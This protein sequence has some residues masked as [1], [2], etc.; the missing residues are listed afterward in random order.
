MR[1]WCL[2]LLVMFAACGSSAPPPTLA[3]G[4]ATSAEAAAPEAA[5]QDCEQ[6]ALPPPDLFLDPQRLAERRRFV[7]EAIAAVQASPSRAWGLLQ[8]AV[9][10]R[11]HPALLLLMAKVAELEQHADCAASLRQRAEAMAGGGLVPSL[12]FP[13]Q[14]ALEPFLRGHPLASYAALGEDLVSR[15]S[16]RFQRGALSDDQSLII[17]WGPDRGAELVVRDA[18]TDERLGAISS[19]EESG[20]LLGFGFLSDNRIVIAAAKA[21]TLVDSVTLQPVLRIPNEYSF[22]VSFLGETA[23]GK[24]FLVARNLQARTLVEARSTTDGKQL[25]SA[26]LP[27]RS[28]VVIDPTR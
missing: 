5:S 14:P 9:Q 16:W 28:S 4:A 11:A 19:T 15:S 18:W 3:A 12:A 20:E 7:R 24:S 1:G 27:S 17:R 22:E 26:E 23:A 13:A 2:S 21:L 6:R 10:I 25:W 8:R